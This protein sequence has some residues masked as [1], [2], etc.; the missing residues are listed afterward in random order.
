[1]VAAHDVALVA[2]DA[3]LARR[4]RAPWRYV[5]MRRGQGDDR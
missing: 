1:M 4:R 5:V 3:A 2:I